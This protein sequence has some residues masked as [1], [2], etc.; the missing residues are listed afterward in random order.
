M[1]ARGKFIMSMFGSDKM[2]LVKNE[3]SGGADFGWIGKGVEVIG[4][5]IFQDKLQVDG[6]VNGKLYSEKGS[7]IIG[8]SGK[9]EGQIDVGTCILHGS[10]N[11][12]LQARSKVE[13]HKTGRL[14]GDVITPA[15][16]VEEGSI[17][18]GAIKMSK[19][20]EIP[21]IDSRPTDKEGDKRKVKEA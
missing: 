19:D 8:E 14:H 15:L 10:I 3:S 17:F 13:I 6:K 9:I 16:V 21:R 20:A 1:A 2:K 7:L 5:V 12:D 11:G 18:N 4:D